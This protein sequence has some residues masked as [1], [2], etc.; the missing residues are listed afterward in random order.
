[1]TVAVQEPHLPSPL[2][3]LLMPFVS[4]LSLGNAIHTDRNNNLD[5]LQ[6]RIAV[7]LQSISW[8]L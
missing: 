6:D 3:Q 8:W 7:L 2:T 5:P 1:M 4:A